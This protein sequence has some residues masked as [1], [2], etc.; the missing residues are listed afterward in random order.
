[1]TT[2]DQ[3]RLTTVLIERYFNAT[4]FVWKIQE[5]ILLVTAWYVLSGCDF[6]TRMNLRT[7]LAVPI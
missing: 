4:G 7:M 6:F 3:F 2:L 5:L 1:M